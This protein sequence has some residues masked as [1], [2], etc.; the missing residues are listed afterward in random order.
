MQCRAYE[1][2]C[3]V[4]RQSSQKWVDKVVDGV[5][6]IAKLELEMKDSLPLSNDSSQ[7]SLE[8]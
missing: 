1:S 6:K 5:E 4:R 2:L 3:G 8:A 7:I